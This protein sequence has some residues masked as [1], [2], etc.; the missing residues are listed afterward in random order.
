MKNKKVAIM[1]IK[2]SEDK[3]LLQL[4]DDKPGILYPASWGLL[5]GSVEEGESYLQ[6]IKRE[7]NEEIKINIEPVKELG[8]FFHPE[9]NLQV[10]V[11]LGKLNKK[12]E[13]IELTEGQEVRFFDIPDISSLKMPAQLKQFILE[14]Q[15]DIIQS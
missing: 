6:A 14:N 5:G 15:K 10:H 13:E 7:I 8:I 3:I 11:F 2:N 9:E 4:R 12:A 1:I